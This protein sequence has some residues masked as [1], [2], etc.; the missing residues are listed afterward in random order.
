MILLANG[1][2]EA[3]VGIAEQFDRRFAVYDYNKCIMI[4]MQ[5]DDM[6]LE[7]AEEWMG[8]NV[9]GAYIGEATPAFVRMMP[10]SSAYAEE[11][12]IRAGGSE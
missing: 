10:L 8:F 4:L 9:V 5:R 11:D 12:R 1:F 6:T 7:E 2:E 3:F